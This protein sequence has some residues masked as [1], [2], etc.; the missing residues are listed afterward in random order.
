VYEC[1]GRGNDSHHDK[2]ELLQCSSNPRFCHAN[3]HGSRR[4]RESRCPGWARLRFAPAIALGCS[5]SLLHDSC[6][7]SSSDGSFSL[8]S[9]PTRSLWRT[10]LSIVMALRQ[11]SSITSGGSFLEHNY[12]PCHQHVVHGC[13]TRTSPQGPEVA[14]FLVLRYAIPCRLDS[15]QVSR[16]SRG[17]IALS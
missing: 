9:P 3:L 16:N 13:H 11:S 1:D 12:S 15:P 14:P 4:A 10:Q 17:I 2:L 6:K 8:P 5:R 7:K